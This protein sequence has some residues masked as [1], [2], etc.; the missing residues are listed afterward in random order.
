MLLRKAAAPETYDIVIYTN[1]DSYVNML[2]D[3]SST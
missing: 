3:L 2:L 1:T